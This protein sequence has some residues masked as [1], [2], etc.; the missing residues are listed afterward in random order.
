MAL[1]AL[2]LTPNGKRDRKALP[3]PEIVAAG[4]R[5]PEQPQGEVE[6]ILA[7]I[8]QQLLHRESVGRHDN[9][10]E[11]GGHSLHGTRLAVE[12][13]QRLHVHLPVIEIFRHPTVSQMA[14]V[15]RSLRERENH[16]TLVDSI[17]TGRHG[18]PAPLAF[19]QLAH[20]N[21]YKLGERRVVRAVASA[22]RL[23]GPL[24]IEALHKS[25]TETVRRHEALR[26]RITV[27][28]AAPV[29]EVLDSVPW[30]L[31]IDDVSE[32]S[33]L[34]REAEAKLRVE[35]FL[36]EPIDVCTDP[37]FAVR[38]IRLDTDQHVLV[39]ATEHIISD[40]I[41]LNVLLRDIVDGYTQVLLGQP[42]DLPAIEAQLTD[43]AVWQTSNLALWRKMHG[44]Y[45]EGRLS[46]C[47]LLRFPRDELVPTGPRVGWG[48]VPLRLDAELRDRL[49]EWCRQRRTTLAMAA[50]T[51]YL[52]LVLRWC[53]ASETII[54]YQSDG[55]TS[56]KLQN[57]VGFLAA[58]LYL[59]VGIGPRDTFL[60]L[61]DRATAEYCE[62]YEHLDFSYFAAQQPP[63]EFTQNTIFNWTPMEA[64]T[65]LTDP[66]QPAP[67]RCSVFPFQHPTVRN[68][69]MEGE[70][71]VAL[72]DTQE[73]I[74][75]NVHFPLNRFS[76]ATMERFA[77]NYTAFV[78]VMLEDPQR[79]ILDVP[80][81]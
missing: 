11:L 72:F 45:W 17:E 65:G 76:Q 23:R 40:G 69:D 16:N 70:P 51:S 1:T 36:A 56:R 6:R 67:L 35:Q 75:G 61:M 44:A 37:L 5:P 49:S 63:P 53:D 57:T 2:P 42:F 62:A 48:A 74:I 38:L 68:L 71:S 66:S 39:I 20:W 8:W 25:I 52:A 12:V 3:V 26:T 77:R 10:F 30:I 19:S 4:H 73:E 28:H 33:K 58:V 80:V 41:S 13:A 78:A 22:T 29:Q 47:P 34:R 50:F 46:G 18:G 54:Q 24:D 32:F 43:C 79:R 55:R 7:E 60:D 21:S 14:A 31:E 15:V 9:F 64:P 27:R 81:Q 59:R